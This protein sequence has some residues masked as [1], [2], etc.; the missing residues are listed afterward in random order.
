M[1]LMKKFK[2]SNFKWVAETNTNDL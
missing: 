2:Q 1:S